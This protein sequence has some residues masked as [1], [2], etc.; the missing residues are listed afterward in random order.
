[1]L[2]SQNTN[3]Q[4]QVFKHSNFGEVRVINEKFCLADVCKILDLEQVSRVKSRLNQKGVTII[5]TPTSGGIQQ[6]NFID[7]ANLYRCIFQSRKP[8]AEMF[9]NWVCEEI[10]PAIR[11]TGGYIASAQEETPELIMAR[12]LQVA[13]ATIERNA[14]QL[15]LANNTIKIQAPKVEY[16][17]EV[18]QSESLIA[19]NVIAKELGMSAISLNK[20]LHD[21]GIIYNSAGT[22]VLYHKYQGLGYTG[23]KTHTYTNS[24]GVEQTHIQTYWTESGRKFIHTLI[25]GGAL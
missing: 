12:A 18:L 11:K 25:K 7:E 6:M 19:T 24:V 20:H 5:N 17:D 23:T 4:I 15:A 21:L 9:Q 16:Y 10:L 3:T 14:Q 22:W 2:N 13:Q 8:E 1:M